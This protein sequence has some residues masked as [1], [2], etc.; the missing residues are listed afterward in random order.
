V[1]G[2]A[3]HLSEE[4]AVAMVVVLDQQ[5]AVARTIERLQ[6]VPWTTESATRAV[7]LGI[8]SASVSLLGHR[9]VD[10]GCL[11]R[12]LLAILKNSGHLPN[13]ARATALEMVVQDLGQRKGPMSRQ[14]SCND[15]LTPSLLSV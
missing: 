1:G 3:E 10:S 6:D 13:R 15:S 4:L 7:A 2:T 11:P 14:V 5:Q 8:I 9:R 12:E